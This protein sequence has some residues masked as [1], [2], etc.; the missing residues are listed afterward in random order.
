MEKIVA[1]FGGSSLADA[2]QF[3][4]VKEVVTS[5]P[6]R[7]V[8]V[9]S[10][11]GKRDSHD[12][13][14]TDLLYMCHQLASH[15]LNFED[16][17]KKIRERYKSICEELDLSVDI[18]AILEEIYTAMQNGASRDYCASRGEYIN[19]I[20]LADYLGYKFV[21]SKDLLFFK[22]KDRL[23]EERTRQSIQNVLSGGGSAVVP[24]FYGSDMKG[25]IQCFSRGG[26]DVT[27]AILSDA[28]QVDLY[29]NWTDVSGFL[30]A[31]P[32]IVDNPEPIQAVTFRELRELS[33]MGANVL[34][35]EAIFPVRRLG[36]PIQIKN[37]N[38]PDDPGTRIIPD[39]QVLHDRGLITGIAGKKDFTVITVE[40]LRM[41]EDLSFFR[42][43][44]SVF[45]TNDVP[46]AHMPS[47]IDS[48]S[49][50]VADSHLNG[51]LK[52][53][54]EEIRIYC[55]PD[56]ID[57]FPSMALIAVVGR[58]MINTKGISARIFKSLADHQVNIRMISQGSSE[59]NVI[60]GIENRDFEE[61]IRAIY[62]TFHKRGE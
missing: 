51:K 3:K 40:K 37:T 52:K 10:A 18:D 62:N 28:L 45:E 34:H 42:K 13:K 30:V 31:D 12:Y 2:T 58:G 1:K 35:E 7:T 8:I 27:G 33:Y 14:I 24:G 50:I 39:S 22:G 6:G 15:M 55:M 25:Q 21:D 9:P 20:L 46:I 23:D 53:I 54:I 11:P 61:A 43:L 57:A 41:T 47:A 44:V 60:V 19:A 4:K 29:E 36:I 26:S 16:V 5:N 49:I 17:F 59:I 56:T 48:V 38:R 32:N